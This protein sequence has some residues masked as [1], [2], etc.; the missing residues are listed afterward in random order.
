MSTKNTPSI[1]NRQMTLRQRT[2]HGGLLVSDTTTK[3]VSLTDT[4][5][6]VSYSPNLPDWRERLLEG[7]DAT[8]TMSGVT[9][10]MTQSHGVQRRIFTPPA[11]AAGSIYECTGDVFANLQYPVDLSHVPTDLVAQA[12]SRAYADFSKRYRKKTQDFGSGVF[13]GEL[14]ETAR[15]LASP[16]KSL[17]KETTNLYEKLRDVYRKEKRGKKANL[18]NA[19]ADTWLTWKFG[20]SPTIQDADDACKAF[21]HMASGRTHDIVRIRGV[22]GMQKQ[23]ASGYYDVGGEIGN[24]AGYTALNDILETSA[25]VR[26]AWKNKSPSDQMP[27]PMMFGLGV[28][29]I[30]P[31]AWE[32]VPWSWL[33]DYFS[34]VGIVLD[35]WSMRFVE[36]AW[37]NLTVRNSKTITCGPL[38]TRPGQDFP[39]GG[40]TYSNESVSR[41]VRY[42]VKTVTREKVDNKFEMDLS[43]RI[44]GF[45]ETKWLNIAAVAQMQRRPRF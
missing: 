40:V 21:R 38:K 17:R 18:S 22:G 42:S 14:L 8:T 4:S 20:I 5:D 7:R 13:A 31:T 39:A 19:V 44:P 23:L 25:M 43:F 41:R 24:S 28:A 36:F 1:T 29:D 34:N 2:V 9:R 16:V 12:V 33:V 6:T 30:V 26:G 37:L 10:H 15:M 3:R 11:Y 45:P 32:L 27:L 35:A